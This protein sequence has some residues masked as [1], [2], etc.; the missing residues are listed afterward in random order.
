[1][2]HLVRV[3]VGAFGWSGQPLVQGVENVVLGNVTKS[4]LLLQQGLDHVG[5]KILTKK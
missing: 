3:S 4:G 2:G 5:T 1:M